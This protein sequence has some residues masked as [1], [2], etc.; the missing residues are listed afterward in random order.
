MVCLQPDLASCFSVEL[1]GICTGVWHVCSLSW[2]CGLDR[3]ALLWTW[4]A[5]G[6]TFHL[7]LLTCSALTWTTL[8]ATKAD[9]ETHFSE[10]GEILEVKL[11]NGFGFI[12]YKD[13]MDARDV[14]PGMH[15]LIVVQ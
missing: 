12:E 14:V 13:S 15:S 2:C 1:S 7:R 10:H 5:R 4:L 6:Y 11:M 9:I 3:N 8:A